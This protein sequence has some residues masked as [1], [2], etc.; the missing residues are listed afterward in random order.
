VIDLSQTYQHLRRPLTHGELANRYAAANRHG[1]L[2]LSEAPDTATDRPIALLATAIPTAATL[3]V[4]IHLLHALPAGIQGKLREELL[5]T[6]ETNAADTLHRCHRTLELDGLGHGY[7]ADE[8]LPAIYDI[9]E[10][11][12]E[13]SRLDQE[14]PSLVQHAQDAVR[15]LSASIACID[16]DSRETTAALT[17]TL[18]RSLARCVRVRRQRPH[19]LR[20]ARGVALKPGPAYATPRHGPPARRRLACL[21]CWWRAAG[22]GQRAS[23][24]PQCFSRGHERSAA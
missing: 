18:A 22:A 10:S 12:L 13:S 11:L 19:A 1:G 24:D 2:L 7:T 3:S 4:A 5:D 15:W 20:V 9:A 17:D 16:E 6:T 8:W 23:R 14:P 21:P